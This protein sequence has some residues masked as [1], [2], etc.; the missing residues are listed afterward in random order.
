M[1]STNSDGCYIDKT[2][3][4][5]IRSNQRGSLP[6]MKQFNLT[7]IQEWPTSYIMEWMVLAAFGDDTDN[8]IKVISDQFDAKILIEIMDHIHWS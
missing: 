1:A 8:S 3:L 7:N 6:Q 2:W 4:S 5:S